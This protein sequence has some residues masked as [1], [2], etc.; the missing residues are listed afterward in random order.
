MMDSLAYFFDSL[1]KLIIEILKIT[2]ISAIAYII[3]AY[4]LRRG[5]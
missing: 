3:L 1:A 4:V 5:S 2:I